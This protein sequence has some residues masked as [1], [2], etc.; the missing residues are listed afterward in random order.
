M[1]N[2]TI[3][4]IIGLAVIGLGGYWF[5]N[6]QDTE[7]NTNESTNNELE[8]SN[9]VENPS[10]TTSYKD[11]AY[12]VTAN[13]LTPAGREDMGVSVVIAGGKVVSAVATVMGKDKTS[14]NLQNR[15][16]G[17]INTEVAGKDLKDL[18]VGVVAGASLASSGFNDALNQIRAQ[19]AQ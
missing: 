1:N 11:G 12:N 9:T 14:I 2:K 18:S 10:S 13:Y 15:F 16:A 8:N 7:T 5:L 6:K 17:G 19:A 4:T 3:F